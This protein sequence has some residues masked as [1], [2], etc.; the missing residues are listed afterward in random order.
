MSHYIQLFL[1]GLLTTFILD[2]FLFLGIKLNYIDPLG[3]RIYFNTF[4]VDNQ[5]IWIYLAFSLFIGWIVYHTKN[6][7]R[8]SVLV[9][10]F[11]LVLATLLPFVG[12]RVGE[13]LFMERNVTLHDKRF[14]YKGDIYYIDREKVLFYDYDLEKMIELEKYTLKENVDELY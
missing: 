2:F 10:L 3:F 9:L 4:F 13:E 5:N 14:T 8:I 1:T 6:V 12:K 7:V 11:L